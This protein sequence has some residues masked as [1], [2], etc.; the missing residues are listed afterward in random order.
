MPRIRLAE[1]ITAG[2]HRERQRR[3]V[4][5]LPRIRVALGTRSIPRPPHKSG[6]YRPPPRSPETPTSNPSRPSPSAV[7]LLALG[8]AAEHPFTYTARARGA[9]ARKVAPPPAIPCS[10]T[11][12]PGPCSRRPDSPPSVSS[13]CSTSARSSPP[14]HPPH[15]RTH[16]ARHWA[17][18]CL[19][20]VRGRGVASHRP[21]QA[22]DKLPP[23]PK[24]RP[25]YD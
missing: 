7:G 25:P 20:T 13:P 5:Q 2:T 1:R 18:H 16:S 22:G 15:L 12:C 17:V 9:H 4:G 19:F 23:T 24:G 3:I 14:P 11:G 10:A 6:R 21:S 8:P